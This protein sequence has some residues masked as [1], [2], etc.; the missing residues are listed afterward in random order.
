MNPPP[1]TAEVAP[2]S[3][4][5]AKTS[6][7]CGLIGFFTGPLTGIPAIITGHIALNRINRSGDAIRGKGLAIT[8]LVLGYFTTFLLT[9]MLVFAAAGFAA[10]NAAIQNARKITT[11]NM[12]ISIE[13]ATNGFFEDYG[14]M[15][16]EGTTDTIIQTDSSP[17]VLHTLL[18]SGGSRGL[19]SRQVKYLQLKSGTDGRNGLSFRPDGTLIGCFDR[20]GNPLHVAFDLDS[21]E[22]LT[23]P[24]HT[25]SPVTLKGRRVAV[26]SDGPDGKSGTRD[27]ITTW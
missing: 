21:N 5:L 25:G 17:E 3:E 26:W 24:G 8:G 23:V 19:N 27:D 1:I 18:G 11:L 4:S 15:P 9:F 2:A 16:M 7:I 13:S 22:T 10:G 14:S 12:M 6:L 20:W